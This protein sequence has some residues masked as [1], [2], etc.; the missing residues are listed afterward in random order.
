M[1][2]RCQN[3]SQDLSH[4]LSKYK[5]RVYCCGSLLSL[6]VINGG[7]ARNLNNFSNVDD[8]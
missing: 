7:L 5:S 6:M 2:S 3:S 1:V 8:M 4:L